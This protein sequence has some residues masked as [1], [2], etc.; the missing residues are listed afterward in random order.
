M[1]IALVGLTVM[2]HIAVFGLEHSMAVKVPPLDKY[3]RSFQHSRL[4]T[5]DPSGPGD[6]HLNTLLD[7]DGGGERGREKGQGTYL[8]V[9]EP[10]GWKLSSLRGTSSESRESQAK[11]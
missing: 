2:R 7:A 1:V 6:R 8:E 4:N 10:M 5:L 9:N 11:A 3:T